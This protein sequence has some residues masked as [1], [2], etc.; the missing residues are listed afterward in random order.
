MIHPSFS[1]LFTHSVTTISYYLIKFISYSLPL[2]SIWTLYS[3][4]IKNLVFLL[5]P[6]LLC[7]SLSRVHQIPLIQT[8]WLCSPRNHISNFFPVI[9]SQIFNSFLSRSCILYYRKSEK[10]GF[11][12]RPVFLCSRISDLWWELTAAVILNF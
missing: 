12:I 8:L 11:L 10:I 1:T 3:K 9:I 2:F 4:I 7:E 5:S 6:S